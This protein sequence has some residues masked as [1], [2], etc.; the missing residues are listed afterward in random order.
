MPLLEC[1][2]LVKDYPG[3]RAVDGVDFFVERGEIV[4]LLGPNGA[5]KTTTFRMVVG[6][7]SPDHG[8]VSLS[9]E[10]VTKQPMYRRAR[11]GL[12][13]LAQQES[14]FKKMSAIDNIR[15][16]LEA[17]GRQFAASVRP[18][19]HLRRRVHWTKER[20]RQRSGGGHAGR[21]EAPA[22]ELGARVVGRE[23]GGDAAGGG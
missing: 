4:G 6:M 3:K 10:D 2:G 20:V 14:V 22:V 1:V 21:V 19:E 12:G 13:Y 11:R 23:R 16:V 8:S 17:R 9:G 15:C 7:I 5:G 18:V